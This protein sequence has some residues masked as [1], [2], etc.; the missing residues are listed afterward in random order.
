MV[1]MTVTPMEKAQTGSASQRTLEQDS[2]KVLT[3]DDGDN[4]GP[5]VLQARGRALG[6]ALGEPAEEAEESSENINKNDST[7]ELPRRCTRPEGAIGAGDE[8]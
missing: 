4:V 7:N 6:E 2:C 8:D 5:V 3:T 1:R